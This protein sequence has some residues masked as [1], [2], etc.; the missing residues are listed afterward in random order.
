MGDEYDS[1]AIQ[2]IWAIIRKIR[3][4]YMGMAD[5]KKIQRDPWEI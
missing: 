2:G 3:G 1:G 4:R 5:A